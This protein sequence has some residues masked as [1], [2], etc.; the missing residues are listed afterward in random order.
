[1]ATVLQRV[2]AL[3]LEHDKKLRSK[4]GIYLSEAYCNDPLVRI[5]LGTRS[6][7]KQTENDETFDVWDYPLEWTSRMDELIVDFIND[8]EE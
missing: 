7:S 2:E 8:L 1:M 3:G 4:L 5:F 6:L